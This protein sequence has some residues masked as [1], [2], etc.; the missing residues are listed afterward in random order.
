MTGRNPAGAEDFPSPRLLR[1]RP[2]PAALT[3]SSAPTR[4]SW[5]ESAAPGDLSFQLG[6]AAFASRAGTQRLLVPRVVYLAGASP[7]AQDVQRRC[8]AS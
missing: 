4:T 8:E 6:P 3:P 1:R 2:R 5:T 7:S